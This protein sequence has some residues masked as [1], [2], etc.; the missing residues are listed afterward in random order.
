MKFLE[1]DIL[2][3]YYTFSYILTK[4]AKEQGALHTNN[5]EGQGARGAF[6]QRAEGG[7]HQCCNQEK[8][9]YNFFTCLDIIH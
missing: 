7:D 2:I 4:L 6:E 3:L 5:V 8:N 9:T 1:T